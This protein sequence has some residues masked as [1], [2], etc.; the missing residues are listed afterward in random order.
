VTHSERLDRIPPYLF[1]ELEHK[2]AEKK[3]QGVD[4]ISL[5][6]GDPDTPTPAPVIDSLVEAA[7]DPPIPVEPRPPRVP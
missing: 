5:G 6:I 2:I 1:A 4:V 3:E 7:R